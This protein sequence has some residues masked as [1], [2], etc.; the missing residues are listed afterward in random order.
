MQSEAQVRAESLRLYDQITSD[1]TGMHK[2]AAQQLT[3]YTREGNREGSFA[4]RI[5]EP[6][7]FDPSM[8]QMD[9]HS[10]QPMMLFEFEPASPFAYT[11]DYGTTPN[12]FV[13]RGRRYPLVFGREQTQEV[14][15]DLLELQTYR[16]DMRQILGDNM[17]KDLVA[18]RDFR[19]I[20]ACRDI[21]GAVN[22]VL[23]WVGK[24]MHQNV[25][26]ALTHTSITRSK[27][28][29]RDT[30]FSIE[31]AKMLM[32]HLR[33]ADWESF[34]VEENRGTESALKMALKGFTETEYGNL[35]LLFTMKKNLIPYSDI[36]QFGAQEFLGRYVNWHEPTMSLE[37]KDTEVRF[38]LYEVFGITIAHPGALTLLKFL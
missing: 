28:V 32:S 15:I 17:T 34:V 35:Q 37:K 25:G 4:S 5:I 10:S 22:T 18:R 14:T 33:L 38:Y 31:P 13:P 9:M 29:M 3:D 12:Q 21:V 26:S 30:I 27:N 1:D 24:A 23:P 36:F 7:E 6:S 2:A 11:V 20:K 19:F 16:Y 8:L